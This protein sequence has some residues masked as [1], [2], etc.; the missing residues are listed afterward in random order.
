MKKTNKGITLVALVITIIILIILAGVSINAVM[1]GGLITNAKDAKDEYSKG[2]V[3]EEDTLSYLDALAKYVNVEITNINTA[4]TNPQAALPEGAVIIEGNANKGIVI[5]DN[6]NNEWVWVEVPKT[7]YTNTTY[8][9]GTAPTS[10]T[11]DS[12]EYYLKIENIMQA[13]ATDYRDEDCSDAWYEG[14][15]FEDDDTKTGE[16][17]YN[18]HKKSML[19]SVYSN[20]GFW[21]G[22]YEAGTRTARYASTD[23]LTDAVVQQNMYPYNYVTISQAQGKAS[24]LATGGKTSSLMFGVQWDLTMKYLEEKGKLL[25]GTDITYEMLATNTPGPT[26]FGNIK[27][28]EFALTSG[29]YTESVSTVGSWKNFDVDSTE[30]VDS[31]KQADKSVLLTTGATERNNTLNIYDIAGNVSGFILEKYANDYSPKCVTVGV[32][33]SSAYPR[34]IA[35]NRGISSLD[36]STANRAFRP[37]LW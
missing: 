4:E 18:E 21:I 3:K 29:Q 36:I 14:C 27:D 20:G 30:V 31:L 15:G 19:K 16:E 37:V 17:K 33:Y 26:A 9:E 8:N 28:A 6:N 32:Y 13:Y 24:T 2:K 35:A 12:D 11:E 23:A 7:I 5:K 22:R 10:L 1:N 25:D 34:A